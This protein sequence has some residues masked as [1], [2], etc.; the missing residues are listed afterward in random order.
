MRDI[1]IEGMLLEGDF[2]GDSFAGTYIQAVCSGVLL[3]DQLPFVWRR[4]HVKEF[5]WWFGLLL[6]AHRPTAVLNALE[7]WVMYSSL[8]IIYIIVGFC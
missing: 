7:C 4:I 6:C 1:P 8:Y 5:L 2:T 3:T